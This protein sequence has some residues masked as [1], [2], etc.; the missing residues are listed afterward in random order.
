[1]K[2][3]FYGFRHG[4]IVGL[5]NKAKENKTVWTK[6]HKYEN[7]ILAV[8][9]IV[10]IELGVLILTNVLTI[11]DGAFLIG[12]KPMNVIFPWALVILGA[13][14]VVLSVF[15]FFIP[16]FAETKHIKG[17]KITQYL[18]NIATVIIFILILALFFIACD[19]LIKFVQ[20]KY[21]ELFELLNK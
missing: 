17:L 1:M 15:S 19:A 6:E 3:L 12:D 8:L 5:Y 4:H 18:V 13:I 20:T 7:L 10:A 9:A 14:S 11:P 16:S 21:G 2:I